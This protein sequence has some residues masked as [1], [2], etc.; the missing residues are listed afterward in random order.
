MLLR[1]YNGRMNRRLVGN[2]GRH[3]LRVVLLGLPGIVAAAVF[4]RLVAHGTSPVAVVVPATAVPHLS[5][6][7]VVGL[8]PPP[9]VVPLGIVGGRERGLLESAWSAGV[10]VLVVADIRADAFAEALV[11]L[12]PDVAV[13]AC[14]PWRIPPAVLR[15]PR[16]GFL[17]LHPSLLPAYRGPAPLFWQFRDGLAT[18]GVS[19]H[20]MDEQLD[21][22]DIAAQ[23]PLALP[24]GVDGPGADRLWAA[25]AADLLLPVLDDLR[26]G[27]QTRIPQPSG[28]SY[29][30]YPTDDDFEL[31]ADWPARRAWVFMRGTE[32]WGRPFAV[33]AGGRVLRLA[34]ALGYEAEGVLGAPY[35]LER[36]EALVQFAPDVLR[37]RLWRR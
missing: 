8:A 6:P 1:V 32:E 7:G 31:A 5:P 14:F 16:R 34:E 15:L 2:D 36:D 12:R 33:R 13:V 19:L 11:A 3:L 9:P 20:W 26:R 27:E 21:T 23:Q 10:A 22:G 37:A 25:A 17:N 4:E 28:G 29:Q 35:R 18:V 30:G 24:A